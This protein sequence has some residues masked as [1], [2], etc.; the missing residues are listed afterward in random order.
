MKKRNGSGSRRLVEMTLKFQKSQHKL[1]ETLHQKGMIASTELKRLST[2]VDRSVSQKRSS[3]VLSTA[4]LI[5]TRV[6][7]ALDRSVQDVPEQR[8]AREIEILQG[9][10]SAD[11]PGVHDRLGV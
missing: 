11:L 10:G 9:V 6:T 4:T 8:E 3:D 1:L 2:S 5:H 7:Q